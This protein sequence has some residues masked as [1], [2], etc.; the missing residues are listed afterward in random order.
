MDSRDKEMNNPLKRIW[1]GWENFQ[2]L[3]VK[4]LRAIRNGL[5]WAMMIDLFLVVYFLKA[6]VIGIFLFLMIILFMSMTLIA[7]NKKGGTD[8]IETQDKP[9]PTKPER[10]P[11]KKKMETQTTTEEPTEGIDYENPFGETM[12]EL[13]QTTD[14]L[15]RQLQD[16]IAFDW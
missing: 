1:Q 11:I 7:E 15:K 10:R 3:P 2:E 9:K 8:P 14:V 5:I 4:T 16:S 13:R 6:T 12:E